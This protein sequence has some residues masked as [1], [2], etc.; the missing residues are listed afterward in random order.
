MKAHLRIARPVR[1]LER[2]A[3]MYRDGLGLE[4]LGTFVDHDGFD[5][6]MLGARAAPYHFELTQCRLRP[7][8]PSPTPED[9]VVLYLPSRDDW[10]AHCIMMETAGFARV[11]AHN[12]YWARSGRTF[13]DPDGYRFV[14]QNA[15]W[16]PEAAP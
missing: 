14:L 7:V 5:G 9:L 11:L 13:A 10:D 16:Q 6:I 3:R 2:S 15:S 4:V 8:T 12:P 1:G